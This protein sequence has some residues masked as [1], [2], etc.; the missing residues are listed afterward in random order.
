MNKYK[1]E[2]DT[3][4]YSNHFNCYG[5][6][7]DRKWNKHDDAAEYVV[8]WAGYGPASMHTEKQLIG[9]MKREEIKVM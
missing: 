1:F 2:M 5:V 3:K 9:M 4:F 7:V 6:V 8:Y